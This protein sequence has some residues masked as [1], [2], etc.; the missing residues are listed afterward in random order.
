MNYVPKLGGWRADASMHDAASHADLPY[1]TSHFE[2]IASQVPAPIREVNGILDLRKWCSPVEDQGHVGSCVGNSVVGALEFLQLRSGKPLVDLSR[3]FVYYNA[4]LMNN[5]ADKDAGSF[6]RMAMGTLSSLGTCSESK[7]PYDVNSVCVRPSWGSYREAY[8][9]KIG[10]FYKIDA[11]GEDLIYNIKHALQCQH[12]VVFGM[13]VDMDYMQYAGGIMPMPG[14]TRVG[15]GMHAQMIC[16][17]DEN[18]KT[19]I[20]RNSWG[21]WWGEAGYAMVPYE[22]LLVSEAN[23]FWVPTALT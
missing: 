20:I 11:T 2:N 6:I 8:A 14:Q 13:V 16:G 23:D 4:R 10:S 19:L 12:P 5:E 22:Y 9:N 18:N 21:T 7:W 3:L 17:Y 15:G 1:V